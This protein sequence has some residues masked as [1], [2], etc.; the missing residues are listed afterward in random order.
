MVRCIIR[1]DTLSTR[2]ALDDS[3]RLRLDGGVGSASAAHLAP[4]R[5]R[6]PTFEHPHATLVDVY[7]VN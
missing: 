5:Q 1:G 7:M 6:T 3:R 4:S 2:V